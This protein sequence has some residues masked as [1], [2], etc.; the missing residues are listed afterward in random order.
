MEAI[1][2]RVIEALDAKASPRR[3]RT[4]ANAKP[5]SRGRDGAESDTSRLAEGAAA[6]CATAERKKAK[7]L[8]LVDNADHLHLDIITALRF[9]VTEVDAIPVLV[10]SAGER[11]IHLPSAELIALEPFASRDLKR[12]V[13]PLLLRSLNAEEIISAVEG[14]A[15]GNPLWVQLLLISWMETGR[16]RFVHG[17]PFLD[18]HVPTEV[19]KTIAETV[20]TIVAGLSPRER[21]LVE[22]MAIWAAPLPMSV[23]KRVLPD[24]IEVPEA[25]VS[26]DGETYRFIA[27]TVGAVILGLLS[28]P[29]QQH[30]HAA[31]LSVLGEDELRSGQRAS[32]L[33]GA[34]RTAE[35]IQALV[36]EASEAEKRKAY[37]VAFANLREALEHYPSKAVAGID[38]GRLALDAARVATLVGELRWARDVLRSGDSEVDDNPSLQLERIV[39]QANVLRELRH[40]GEAVE[41]YAEARELIARNPSLRH[42]SVEVQLEEAANDATRGEGERAL[43]GVE[44]IVKSLQAEGTSRLLGLALQRLATL[45]GHLGRP[46]V[47]CGFR[48]SLRAH[49]APARRSP[50]GRARPGQP[51]TVSIDCSAGHDRP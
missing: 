18:D 38:R 7:L 51:R 12:F 8:L 24:G 41:L 37:R 19:P 3:E 46:R 40:A 11:A 48:A 49:R 2:S 10:V 26:A 6:I 13:E 9:L 33:L 5:F 45:H 20:S 50:A 15:A 1:H 36:D 47:G 27:D 21:E 14:G 16:L 30:W 23:A 44:T 25:I 32:H 35:G 17:R 31:F 4:E 28:K 43:R 29:R 34:G 39:L 42:R 22:A